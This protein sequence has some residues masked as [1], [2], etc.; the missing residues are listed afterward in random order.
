MRLHKLTIKA[1]EALSEALD[2]ATQHGH[3]EI[4]SLH[5][6]HA[7][8]AQEGGSVPSILQRLGVRPEQILAAIEQKLQTQP[9]VSGAT[10]QTGL[11]SAANRMLE[12]AW[13]EAQALKDQYLSTEHILLGM[14]SM[15]DDPAGGLLR[16][17][18]ATRDNLLSAMQQVRGTQ[19]VTDPNAEATYE[20]LAKYSRDLTHLARAG[21]LDPVIGAI[22]R[23]RRVIQV[24][25]R[26]T[27]NNPCLSA[28]RAGQTA[29]VEGSPA[30]RR[31]RRPRKPERQTGRRS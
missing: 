16:A 30:Y 10:T 27:K 11:S 4:N 1:Q 26:R 13:N 25:S 8:V 2:A 6:L 12:S 28:N 18:G 9:R 31:G 17:H 20:A 15:R 5:I 21:K 22:S 23:V 24:L 3:P 19:R 29:I 14:V 7:L